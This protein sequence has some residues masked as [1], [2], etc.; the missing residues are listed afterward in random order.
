MVAKLPYRFTASTDIVDQGTSKEVCLDW[1]TMMAN[2]PNS[3][4]VIPDHPSPARKSK[5]SAVGYEHFRVNFIK[6]YDKYQAAEESIRD[7]HLGAE[8]S[9]GAAICDE[10]DSMRLLEF[11]ESSFTIIEESTCHSEPFQKRL[12][13]ARKGSGFK[14]PIVGMTKAK[15]T[16]FTKKLVGK[17]RTSPLASPKGHKFRL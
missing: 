11:D 5:G 6:L 4:P 7:H 2:S 1:D 15:I 3:D 17:L 16:T 14:P 13:R 9:G 8:E 12:D 10:F